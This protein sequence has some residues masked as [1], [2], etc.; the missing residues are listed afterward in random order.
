MCG[1]RASDVGVLPVH[2]FVLAG[3]RSVRMGK[4]KALLQF[5]GRP[6]VKIAVEKLREFCAEVRIAGSREDLSG[7]AP[8]VMDESEEAGPAAGR[9]V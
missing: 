2:G 5:S 6:M 1:V 4:D 8:V 3:G 7:F 9:C